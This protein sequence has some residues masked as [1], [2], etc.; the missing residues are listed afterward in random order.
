MKKNKAGYQLIEEK[1]ATKKIERVAR[2]CYKSEDKICEGSDFKMIK[3]LINRKHYAMLEH[4][5]ICVEVNCELYDFMQNMRK[6]IQSTIYTDKN[7]ER[8]YLRFSRHLMPVN[9][10][11]ILNAVS[12]YLISGN[13]RAWIEMFENLEKLEALP[14]VLCDAIV[15]A[16]GGAT[17]AMYHF[18]CH[19]NLCKEYK[20]SEDYEPDWYNNIWA[21]VVTDYS[22][23]SPEERMLH[24]TF[25]ILFTCD[26]GITHE[27][28]R[29]REASFSQESTRYCNYSLDKHDKQIS[30]I[31][32][33]FFEEGTEAYMLWE[34][35]MVM[36]EYVYLRLTEELGVPAQQA[37]AVLP[38]SICADI[39]M[40][41]NLREWRHVFDLRACDSTG[42]CHPQ[43]SEIM[44][45]CFRDMREKYPFAFGDLYTPDEVK[46]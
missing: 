11:S 36:S 33:F 10:S 14:A 8:C 43:M 12:R 23:L 7:A 40:T 27:L 22:V 2:I 21:K 9:N 15:E 39:A 35:V 20:F 44:R 32:P 13:I 30:V 4:A 29:M 28:V 46:P 18:L 42:P 26:R 6:I 1:S 34:Q 24:E 16:A 41:A 5:D 17:G 38:H 19:G 45:P 3:N 31:A 37:R 25:T